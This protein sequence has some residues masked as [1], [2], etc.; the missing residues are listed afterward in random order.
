MNDSD[1]DEGTNHAKELTINTNNDSTRSD[2]KE[3]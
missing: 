1:L 3:F 2:E